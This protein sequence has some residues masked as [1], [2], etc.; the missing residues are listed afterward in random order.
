MRLSWNGQGRKIYGNADL[1]LD[2]WRHDGA[3]Y[4]RVFSRRKGLL[5]EIRVPD[6]PLS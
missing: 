1:L 5:F 2:W 6:W 4:Y 3:S